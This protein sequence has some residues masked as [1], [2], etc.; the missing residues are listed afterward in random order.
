[1][2]IIQALIG[3]G[4]QVANH[5]PVPRV[6]VDDGLWRQAIDTLAEGKSSLLSL[7]ATSATVHMALVADDQIAIFSLDCPRGRFPSAIR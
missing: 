2:S 3:Q 5:R 4:K 1:M 6:L 7:W